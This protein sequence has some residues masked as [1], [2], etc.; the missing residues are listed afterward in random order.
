MTTV[1]SLPKPFIKWKYRI[2]TEGYGTWRAQYKKPFKWHNISTWYWNFFK[3]DCYMDEY[4]MEF[5]TQ[6]EAQ[7]HCHD[8]ARRRYDR[9][10]IT[11]GEKVKIINLGELP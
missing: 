8:H 5:K 9:Y 11:K 4:V 1:N 3:I 7:N 2:G 6:T 10:L